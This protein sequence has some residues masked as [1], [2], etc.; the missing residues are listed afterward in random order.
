MGLMHKSELAW[1]VKFLSFSEQHIDPLWCLVR[2]GTDCTLPL[3]IR[4]TYL[5]AVYACCTRYAMLM[6]A[7]KAKS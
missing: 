2:F 1:P 3:L 5:S 4:C 6:M 7:T